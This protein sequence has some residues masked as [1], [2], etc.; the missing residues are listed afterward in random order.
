MQLA[1]LS[2]K[3]ESARAEINQEREGN[4]DLRRKLASQREL[5]FDLRAEKDRRQAVEAKL[6]EA[7]KQ[8][9]QAHGAVT[10]IARLKHDKQM[11]CM[12]CTVHILD[13]RALKRAC[14]ICKRT[15]DRG[16]AGFIEVRIAPY[17]KCRV[18]F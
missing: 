13:A 1:D 3:L 6:V 4:V 18:R 17:T 8:A 9:A 5:E 11:V 7:E 15:A 16:R 12:V 2:A 10:E 14:L